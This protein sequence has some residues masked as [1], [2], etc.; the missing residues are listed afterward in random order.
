MRILFL[1]ALF[2]FSASS[3]A[4][5]K[6]RTQGTILA[7]YGTSS[8]GKTSLINAFKKKYKKPITELGLDLQIQKMLLQLEESEYKEEFRN[9][10]DRKST[11]L[12]SSHIQKSRMPSSA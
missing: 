2:A 6:N 7:F 12:N 10:A 9:A 8:S 11:R 3:L 5:S 1:L 4:Y